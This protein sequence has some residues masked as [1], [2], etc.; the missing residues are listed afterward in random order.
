[1][2]GKFRR[3]SRFEVMY[4][5]LSL[6]K[7]LQQKTYIMFKC[8][9]SYSLLQKYLEILVSANMLKILRKEKSKEYY[10]VTDRGE[11]FMAEYEK[12]QEMLRESG[13]K[14]EINGE[15]A[16]SRFMDKMIYKKIESR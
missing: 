4:Q 8:N 12:L 9:L 14:T 13:K 10:I 15:E 11:R 1:M 16:S 5:I 3:R 2:T 7:T 6:C